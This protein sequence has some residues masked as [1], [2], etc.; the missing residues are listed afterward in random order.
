MSST[1]EV[2]RPDLSDSNVDKS[3]TAPEARND[4]RYSVW[5]TEPEDKDPENPMNWSNG[6]KWGIIS[7][8]SI[9]TFLTPLA[10]AMMAPGVP[11]IMAEFNS[12]NNMVKTFVVSIFVLGFAIG[13]LL[14]APL[15]ELYGRTPVYHVCNVLFVVFTVA[16]ALAKNQEMMLAF[17]FFSGFFGVAVVTC[18]SASISDM[19]PPEQRGRAMAIWSIGPLIGPVIGPV[20]A[21]FLVESVGWRWVF[22]VTAIAAGAAVVASFFILKE[23]YAPILLERKAKTLRK[24]TG[25]DS[26]RSRLEQSGS[27]RHIIFAAIVRPAKLFAL[28]P[29][30]AMS[31][32]YVAALYGLLYLLFTT[33][34]FVYKQ[35]YGFGAVGAGN[36]FIAGGVGNLLGL[37]F[38][39][40]WSDRLVK[41]AKEAGRLSPEQRLDL[42]LTVPTALALPA[43][44]LIYG[45]TAQNRV[46]WIAPMIGTGVL[47]F[48]MIG[49]FMVIQTYLVDAY[50]PYAASVTAANAVLRSILGA[51]LP[52]CGLQL[53]EA[54]DL[55]WGNTLLALIAL[56]LAPIPWIL[57]WRGERLR[58]HPRFK[59]EF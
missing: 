22:W 27:P 15:S 11:V 20:C 33:F 23:T 30:V 46:H 49:I 45:W 34:T 17:R 24:E 43:G 48:G 9:L 5:W 26:Y 58:N 16:C 31:C 21:G 1:A 51:L 37:L 13:P 4:D 56:L 52:L 3:S 32:T 29:V 18:G 55:G 6:R 35:V 50:T 42:R 10:S 38:V 47:G 19:M 12:D 41:S 14:M 54:L 59:R 25:D 36:S 53:Y 2:P 44:L 57:C 28:S 8:L 40:Y 7:I 39:G